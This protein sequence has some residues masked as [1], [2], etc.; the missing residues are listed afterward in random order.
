[1]ISDAIPVPRTAA[2]LRPV[3]TATLLVML[4]LPFRLYAQPEKPGCPPP[5]PEP[6]MDEV[7]TMLKS[8]K[9]RG[10]LWKFEKNGRTGYLY[11]SLHIGKR[12]WMVPGPKTIAALQSSDVIA[13]ELDVLAPK[14]Q[15]QMFNPSSC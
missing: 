7:H 8:A 4:L 11:G 6:T 10:V 13:L 15:A 3:F 9:D 14:V 5:P 1:M 12:D 2:S